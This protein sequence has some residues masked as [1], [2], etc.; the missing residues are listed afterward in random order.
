ML[1]TVLRETYE[2]EERFSLLANAAPALIWMSDT[3]KLCTYVNKSWLKFTGRSID[4]ELGSGWTE[5]VHPEDLR[6][7]EDTYTQAFDCR[8]EFRMEY[9]LRR[10]DGEY[11]WILDIGVPR[12]DKDRSFVGYIGIGVDVTERKLAEM[13]LTSVSGKLIEAQEQER[14]RIAR[15]L[16]DDFNQRLAILSIGLDQLWKTLPESDTKGRAKVQ[17]ILTGTKELSSDLHALAYRLHSSRLEHVGLASAIAGHCKEISEKYKIEVQFNEGDLHFAIPKDVALCLFR[18]TQE[19]LGNVVKHS[20]A[21]SV[22]VE[23]SA[24]ASGVSLRISDDGK[25]FDTHR[26]NQGVGIGLIGMHERIRLVAGR[27]S[28]RSGPMHGTVILAEVPLCA[29]TNRRP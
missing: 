17:E 3:D 24:S 14:T 29:G 8:E 25:G 26:T 16:H 2:S 12:F 21:K 28:I 22:R 11:R 18:V 15:E 4:S 6:R 10:Y 23:L 1:D 13:A 7:R 5:V 20:Q 27:L 19:A 9:R